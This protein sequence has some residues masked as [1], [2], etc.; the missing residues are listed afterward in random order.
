MKVL[1]VGATGGAGRRIV[2][3]AAA[4]GH[5]VVALVRSSAKARD[6]PGAQLVE[7]DARDESRLFDAL[8]GCSGVISSIGTPMSPFK[9][10]TLLS[11]ATQALVNAMSR[12]RIRRE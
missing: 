8:D 1:V 12:R 5:S 6:L 11:T 10:V 9:K 7:G 4:K 3:E 2:S